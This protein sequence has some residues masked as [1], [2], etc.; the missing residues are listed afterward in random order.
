MRRIKTWLRTSMT[1]ERFSDLSI[2]HIE[3]EYIESN[4]MADKFLEHRKK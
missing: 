2:L 3:K 1:Q 4:V